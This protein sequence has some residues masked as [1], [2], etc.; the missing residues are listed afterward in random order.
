MDRLT[1]LRKHIAELVVG[2]FTVER[3]ASLH[4][5]EF[6]KHQAAKR[7]FL[8]ANPGADLPA[9]IRFG[10]EIAEGATSSAREEVEDLK[11]WLAEARTGLAAALPETSIFTTHNLEALGV[12]GLKRHYDGGRV[13][14][15]PDPVAAA[16]LDAGVALLPDSI[17]GRRAIADPAHVPK[18]VDL[19]DP[20]GFGVVP[21]A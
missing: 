7:E 1:R 20:C 9:P 12:D 18:L 14:E 15:V 10:L 13:H 2:I 19:G 17:A 4:L 16:A 6:E 5:A 3:K 11:A 21:A 8:A